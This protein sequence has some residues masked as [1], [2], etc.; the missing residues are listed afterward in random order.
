M[1]NN[2]SSSEP[3]QNVD[4]KNNT[5]KLNDNNVI[6]QNNYIAEIENG[7][8]MKCSQISNSKITDKEDGPRQTLYSDDKP[9]IESTSFQLVKSIPV[10]AVP[11]VQQNNSVNSLDL[12]KIKKIVN[13]APVENIG[14]LNNSLVHSEKQDVILD[15]VPTST[16]RQIS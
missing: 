15:P 2:F 11:A 13:D 3:L 14:N 8:S 7:G 1:N 12:Q 4:L 10:Q 6:D 9:G 16:T 5:S